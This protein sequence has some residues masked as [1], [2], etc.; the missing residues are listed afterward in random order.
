[1][2]ADRPSLGSRL[3]A[4]RG[5]GE[6]SPGATPPGSPARDNQSDPIVRMSS[7]RQRPTPASRA[8]TSAEFHADASVWVSTP[9]RA[10][11]R[12][13]FADKLDYAF[14]YGEELAKL[15]RGHAWLQ[16]HRRYHS[17]RTRG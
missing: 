10:S 3:R 9:V 16:V 7:L 4:S 15:L 6:T 1:M 8:A 12:T 11:Q 13:E 5:A 17:G 2:S 14:A